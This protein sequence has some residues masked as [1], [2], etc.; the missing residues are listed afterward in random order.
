MKY[1][2]ATRSSLVAIVMFCVILPMAQT[3]SVASFRLAAQQTTT[4]AS[5]SGRIEDANGL[6]ISGVAVTA[7][8]LDTNQQRAVTSDSEGRYRFAYL[9]V[10]NY[11]IT[12]QQQ[13]FN[14]FER[15]IVLTVG[16]SV[17]LQLKLSV[18]GIVENVDVTGDAAGV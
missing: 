2:L 1:R 18:S 14:K 11:L 3:W 10:G 8:K 6:F 4:S 5:L 12:A 13:G 9:P 17:D 15:Q 7:T 16:Q